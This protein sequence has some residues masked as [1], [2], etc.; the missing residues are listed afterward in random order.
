ML[1][2]P[3][4]SRTLTTV[5]FLALAAFVAAPTVQAQQAG[6]INQEAILAQMPEMQEAQEQL[7]Q[8][9]QSERQ[10]LQSEQQ[11]LQQRVQQFQ[12][13]GE[14]MTEQSRQE[15]MQELRQQQEQLQQSMQERDQQIAQ[16]ERELLRPV[17]DKFQTAVDAV[18]SERD[19]N[20]VIR[21]QAL[22]YVSDT[23]MV[24]ITDAVASRLGVEVQASGDASAS[25]GR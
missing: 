11:Q 9:I 12:E 23:Q 6:Y 4:P 22:L 8:E 18:A 16:R 2:R 21:D 17:F 1:T 15:R 13:Q 20:F 19:L 5:L 10:Q 7:Q 24:D 3:L 25:S 14:M